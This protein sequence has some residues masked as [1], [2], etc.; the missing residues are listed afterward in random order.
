MVSHASEPPGSGLTYDRRVPTTTWT[1]VHEQAGSWW[2][3]LLVGTIGG[4]LAG[5]FGVGG[6]ILMVPLLIGLAGMD[7]RRASATSL[8]A[9]VPTSL[10]G[11]LSYLARG[12]SDVRV[13]ALAAA[14]GMIGS[15]LGSRLLR[16]IHLTLLRWLF[17]ALLVAVAARLLTAVPVRG[18]DVRLS[19]GVGLLVLTIGAVTGVTAGLFGI[20]GGIILVPALIVLFGYSDL[21]AKGTSLL[22]MVPT[23]AVGSL[24]NLRAGQVDLR[25]GAVVGLA[26]TAAS[27]VGV[28]LAFLVPPRWS[29]GLFAAL[30]LAAAAQ[31][32]VRM[33]R[34][35]RH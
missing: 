10:A 12:E 28:A 30:I 23:A 9:I 15:W 7:H 26:A 16:R 21:L 13:A 5:A 14:G 20:G 25:A 6:G 4:L 22:A 1:G 33:V 8:L 11:S 18:G 35:S 27:F 2:P 17:V 32:V 3:L 34:V 24:A 19:V 31:M 29:S